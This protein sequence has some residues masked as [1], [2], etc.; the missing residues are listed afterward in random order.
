MTCPDSFSPRLKFKLKIL[1]QRRFKGAHANT[2]QRSGAQT[3]SPNTAA[4]GSRPG[5]V[6]EGSSCR[7]K[8][9]CAGKPG[10][11][12]SLDADPR[13]HHPR[14]RVQVVSRQS[15]PDFQPRRHLHINRHK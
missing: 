6:L 5:R 3:P 10:Q 1:S 12:G 2:L 11:E 15:A 9:G 8:L 14:P 7:R 13:R 4:H